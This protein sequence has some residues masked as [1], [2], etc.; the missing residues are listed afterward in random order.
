[1]IAT[2]NATSA[3]IVLVGAVFLAAAVEM[4]EALT[5]V[6]AVGHTRGWRSAFEGV[7]VALVALAALVAALGPA[8]VEV[9]L[10]TLRLIVG[11]VLLIFGLQW[12]RKAVLRSSGF[13]AKHDEDAI[14]RETVASL[15][16]TGERPG[17]DRVAFVVA[18]KGV[19]LEGLEIVIA[20]L[21]LG[22]SAHRL[23][24]AAAV[25]GV[26][27]VLVGIVG[28]VVAKQLSNVPENAMKMAVGI[29]LVSYG[30]FWT[31]EGLKI[32]WPGDDVMLLGLVVIYALAAAVIVRVLALSAP[33]P[34][35]V[36]S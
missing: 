14:Y 28:V 12:L 13:K 9:P 20:V 30:T 19:F 36:N 31:G 18:F 21:T 25:A 2:V 34:K 6:L 17:R 10:S 1:M 26:A 23:G 5:I 33:T 11:I 32:R 15:A 22:T 29:M 35:A 3:T 4:V 8:L 27:V 7:G 24:L 16:L